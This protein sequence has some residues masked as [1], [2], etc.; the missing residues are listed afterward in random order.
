MAV[1][2]ESPSENR[3][4]AQDQ[5]DIDDSYDGGSTW[6]DWGDHRIMEVH[7]LHPIIHQ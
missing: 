2:P 4:R 1:R 3:P 5:Q 6:G 7:I